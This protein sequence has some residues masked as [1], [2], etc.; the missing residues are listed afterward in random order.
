MRF[1]QVQAEA[2]DG[3]RA[4]ERPRAFVL[5]GRRYE[6]A[7]VLDRWYEGGLSPRD[8]KLD[9]FKVRTRE[10]REFIL[11]YN[12]LFDAWSVLVPAEEPGEPGSLHPAD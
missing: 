3:Y 11:R 12:A 5:E 4:A 8:Q 2:Y 6:V 1:V 7:Q 10:G 9:Y